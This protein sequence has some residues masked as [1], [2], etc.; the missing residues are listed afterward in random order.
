M[1]SKFYNHSYDFYINFFIIWFNIIF[2]FI[3]KIEKFYLLDLINITY[4]HILIQTI[5]SNHQII[6]VVKIGKKINVYMIKSY[7]NFPRSF[8]P[9]KINRNNCHI[10]QYYDT[11]Q[12]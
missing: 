9:H 3:I 4:C 7:N 1:Y 12:I 10:T 6:K 2:Y 8:I 11:T 5:S